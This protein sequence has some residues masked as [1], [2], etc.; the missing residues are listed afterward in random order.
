MQS[1]FE[2]KRF[3]GSLL[4]L[5]FVNVFAFLLSMRGN[6][7]S[8]DWGL[9]ISNSGCNSPGFFVS[10]KIITF[11]HPNKIWY[12]PTKYLLEVQ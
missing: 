9:F 5:V 8:I 11:I 2:T 1:N 6:A 3:L 7:I 12:L 10:L 4:N